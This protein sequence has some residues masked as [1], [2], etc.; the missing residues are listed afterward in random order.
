MSELH[1][2]KGIDVVCATMQ[3]KLSTGNLAIRGLVNRKRFEALS[4]PERVAALRDALF[5][6]LRVMLGG[7]LDEQLAVL[8]RG[9]ANANV[10]KRLSR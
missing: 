6:R 3:I 1:I 10:P 9:N 8:V 4:Q 2:T 5:A 7:Q